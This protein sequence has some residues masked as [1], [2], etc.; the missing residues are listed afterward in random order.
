MKKTT[1]CALFAMACGFVFAQAAAPQYLSI[2][3]DAKQLDKAPNVRNN[4]KEPFDGFFYARLAAFNTNAPVDSL[5]YTIKPAQAGTWHVFMK[6]RS[7]AAKALDQSAAIATILA[8]STNGFEV[9]A[10]KYV[11]GSLGD[12]AW[13]IVSLGVNELKAGM[14]IKLTPSKDKDALPRYTDIHFI[15]LVDPSFISKTQK[16]LPAP[17]PAAKPAAKK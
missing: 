5:T 1:L 16:T 10:E 11:T 2:V 13:Q 6:V 3:I 7:G 4:L 15:S 9:V 8:P 14:K 12:E 17:K